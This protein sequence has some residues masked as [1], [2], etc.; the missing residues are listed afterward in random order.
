M[1]KNGI[2]CSGFLEDERG[3]VNMV[4]I[5]L[6]ILVVIALIAIFRSSLMDLLRTLFDKIRSEA[7]QI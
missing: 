7:M 2:V 4:A 6:I 1:L 5:V 3:E